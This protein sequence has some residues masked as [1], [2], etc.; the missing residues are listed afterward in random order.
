MRNNVQNIAK[1][2]QNS[3]RFNYKL[4]CNRKINNKKFIA[5]ELRFN[6]TCTV[7]LRVRTNSCMNSHGYNK[8]TTYTKRSNFFIVPSCF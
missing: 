2:F 3:E 7:S 5:P 1:Y 4:T 6:N 8:K